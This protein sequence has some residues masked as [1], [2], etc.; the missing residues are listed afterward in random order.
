MIADERR[1]SRSTS[2]CPAQELIG[3][4][5]LRLHGIRKERSKCG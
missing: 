5:G 1:N 3:D 2:M 4:D